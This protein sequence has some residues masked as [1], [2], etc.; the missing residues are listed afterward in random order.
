MTRHTQELAATLLISVALTQVAAANS[1]VFGSNRNGI[2]GQSSAT[3]PIGS[4]ALS[5][6]A[7]PAPSTFHETGVS[8]LGV[9]SRAIADATDDEI[10]K[11]SMI[12]GNASASGSAEFVT[13]SFDQPGILTEID[14][15]GVK[16]ESFEYFRLQTATSPDLY[17]FDSFI[18]STADPNQINVPGQVVFLQE[19]TGTNDD[20]SP[21]LSIPFAAGQVFTLTYGQQGLGNGAPT[22]RYDGLIHPRARDRTAD[23]SWPHSVDRQNLA[24]SSH[25]VL[26]EYRETT[27]I[28]A[29][30]T[31]TQRN[32]LSERHR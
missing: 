17:F 8:G 11:F 13:F 28:P 29:K 9:N 26:V 32:Q 23:D 20:R 21:E 30:L 18:G 3:V 19:G 6:T 5:L 22:A 2:H 10:D 1:I 14:F 16:D 24:N 12:G 31:N 27:S 25:V 15:D 4:F 7:G